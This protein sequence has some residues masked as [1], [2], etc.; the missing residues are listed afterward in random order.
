LREIYIILYCI[1][2]YCII[3]YYIILYY[4]ILYYIILYYI[5]L[6]YIISI[7]SVV[8]LCYPVPTLRLSKD[9]HVCRPNIVSPL[10]C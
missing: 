5:I 3:L 2:L 4:I 1:V 8:G 6:Y 10:Q 7:F 9:L